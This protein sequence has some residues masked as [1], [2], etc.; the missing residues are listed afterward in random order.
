MRRSGGTG[1]I[2]SKPYADTIPW[3]HERL[4]AFIGHDFNIDWNP[5]PGWE[6]MRNLIHV[7]V[8]NWMGINI[9]EC[10]DLE[11]AMTT[12]RRL[13][14]Y[15]FLITFAPLPVEGGTGSPVNPLAIF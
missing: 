2:A 13:N 12:A 6:G 15:D 9:V 1:S 10:L 4:P 5:R 7:A 11:Q 14:R 3:M 8:L